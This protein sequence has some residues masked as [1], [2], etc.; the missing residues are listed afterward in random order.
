[1]SR[2]TFF[3]SNYR[4]SNRLRTPNLLIEIRREF[5]RLDELLLTV[6]EAKVRTRRRPL[7]PQQLVRNTYAKETTNT[8]HSMSIFN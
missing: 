5:H 2:F 6:R 4:E 8:C 1:M 3:T 7:L